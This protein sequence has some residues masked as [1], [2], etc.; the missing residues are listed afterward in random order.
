MNVNEG[1]IQGLRA[2]V[3]AAV[4]FDA[5]KVIVRYAGNTAPATPYANVWMPTSGNREGMDANI[6]VMVD[7]E[8]GRVTVGNRVS[9]AEVEFV[10]VDSQH[11]AMTAHLYATHSPKLS[12]TFLNDDGEPIGTVEASIRR[13]S[14]PRDTT[15]PLETAFQIRTLIELEVAYTVALA[16]PSP[17]LDLMLS[18]AITAN[19]QDNT[20]DDL[21]TVITATLES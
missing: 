19:L 6:D 17:D 15:T 2:W 7:D 16:N 5:D 8:A 21:V 4:G 3:S 18:A 11:Y 9:R 12:H 14:P 20:G 1:I 13:C 10:G